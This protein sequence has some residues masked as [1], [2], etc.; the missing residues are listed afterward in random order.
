LLTVLIVLILAD[1]YGIFGIIMAPPLAAAIQIF[2]RNIQRANAPVPEFS[3]PKEITELKERAMNA[4]NL[5]MNLQ[6]SPKAQ[7]VSLLDRL[8]QL[9]EKASRSIDGR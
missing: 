4:R 2:F 1:S 5:S 9:I 3:P 6:E 8:D 7:T